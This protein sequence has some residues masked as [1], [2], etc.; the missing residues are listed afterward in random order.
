MRILGIETSSR[1]ATAAILDDGEILAEYTL[2]HKK[3]HSQIMQPAVEKLLSDVGLTL[4][5]IDVFACGIGPGSFTGLR[6][7]VSM[8]KGFAQALGK[9]TAGVSTLLALAQNVSGG[10]KTVVSLIYARA[11]EVFYGIYDDGNAEEG[12]CAIDELLL[13]VENKNCIFVG[14]GA[15]M[16]KEKI[17]EIMGEKATFGTARQN[18]VSGA[19][20]CILAKEMADSGKLS[21]YAELSPSYM[22]PSQAEREFG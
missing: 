18:M 20:V 1:V 9:T 13:K 8:I 2:N 11:D 16:F 10:D 19:N 21:S 3:T 12:V 4:S 14:D 6:I 7:G 15:V 17:T 22:R 5:D